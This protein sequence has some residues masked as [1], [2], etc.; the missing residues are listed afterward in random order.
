MNNV[1][2]RNS[3]TTWLL[4]IPTSCAANQPSSP[5]NALVRRSRKTLWS[6]ARLHRTMMNPTAALKINDEYRRIQ[7]VGKEKVHQR[8]PRKLLEHLLRDG[9]T[10]ARTAASLRGT[11]HQ[12]RRAHHQLQLLEHSSP[13]VFFFGTRT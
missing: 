6:T 12:W 4:G 1:L 3:S 13:C 8:D 5:E 10:A 11:G 2:K 7:N 9:Q